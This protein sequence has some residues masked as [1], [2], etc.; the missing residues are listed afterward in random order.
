MISCTKFTSINALASS[1]SK[2]GINVTVET[3]KNDY[4]INEKAK[5]SIS[6]TNTNNI[7]INNVSLDAVL[8]DDFKIDE[9][10][11]K[12]EI[13]TIKAGQNVKI[14]VELTFVGQSK[15]DI[16]KQS[17]KT[18]ESCEI[19]VKMIIIALISGTVIILSRKSKK[20]KR[21]LSVILIITI[22]GSC[23]PANGIVARANENE[24]SDKR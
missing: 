7:D 22:V 17:P 2:D 16:N 3:D 12:K 5:V 10:N 19:Y 9:K 8:P 23:M 6:I 24:N 4:K 20:F 21:L 14:E 18:G 11:S 1:N 15:E 13:G